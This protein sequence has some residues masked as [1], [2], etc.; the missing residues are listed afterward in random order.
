MYKL[1]ERQGNHPFRHEL[2]EFHEFLSPAFVPIREIRGRLAISPQLLH[3]PRDTRPSD[4]RRN[5]R[6]GLWRSELEIYKWAQ[7]LAGRIIWAT[8]QKRLAW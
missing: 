1:G 2:H 6:V 7:D 5:T 8:G 4:F 3:T